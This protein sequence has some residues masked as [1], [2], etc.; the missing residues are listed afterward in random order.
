MFCLSS[1]GQNIQKYYVFKT[2]EK[3]SLFH[4]LPVVLFEDADGEDFSYDLTYT[5]WNDTVAMNFTYTR[6]EPLLID[7]VGY[8]SGKNFIVCKAEKIYVEPTSKKWVHRYSMKNK[9]DFFSQV[10]NA[11]V[12]PEIVIYCHN[13]NYKYYAKKSAW[14]KYVPIGQ[15]LFKMIYLQ[16]NNEDGKT[17]ISKDQGVS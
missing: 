11:D 7:S 5:S 6:T 9:S 8:F 17:G 16:N 10:Y 4:L 3:G 13:T 2:Q 14:R 12:T 1:Y 15:K